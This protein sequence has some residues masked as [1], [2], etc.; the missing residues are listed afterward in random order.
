MAHPQL[1]GFPC[2]ALFEGSLYVDANG[3]GVRQSSEGPFA[4]G[5]Q[6]TLTMSD[7]STVTLTSDQQG[8]LSS[9]VLLGPGGAALTLPAG[10]TLSGGNAQEVFVAQAGQTVLVQWGLFDA[11]T[12]G[13]IS[14]TV[15][16]DVNANGLRDPGEPPLA[17]VQIFVTQSDTVTVPLLTNALGQY[18]AA[19]VPPGVTLV[20]VDEAQLD[21]ILP[22]GTASVGGGVCCVCVCFF[23][24]FFSSSSSSLISK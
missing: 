3:D 5:A 13:S 14:G 21:T 7:G 24:F 9:G 20:R 22:G 1:S 19:G 18:S 11:T 4:G 6:V 8:R 23:F 12:P 2:G 15:F 16:N 10:F 17:G